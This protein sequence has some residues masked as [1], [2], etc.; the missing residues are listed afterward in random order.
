[1]KP[2]LFYAITRCGY[3]QIVAVTTVIDRARGSQ[4]HGRFASDNSS[5]H[6]KL[7]AIVGRFTTEERAEAALNDIKDIIARYDER[8]AELHRAWSALRKSRDV[9]IDEICQA[10]SNV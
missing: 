3:S 7:N 1:M 5:T 6:G 4:W 9:E 2:A 8:N 10:T